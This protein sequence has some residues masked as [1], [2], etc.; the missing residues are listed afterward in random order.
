MRKVL[1]MDNQFIDDLFLTQDDND[2]RKDL[3]EFLI[4]DY[5]GYHLICNFKNEIEYQKALNENP[6][7]EIIIDKFDTIDYKGIIDID[8]NINKDYIDFVIIDNGM[9]FEVFAKN[10]KNILNPYFTTKKKGA[11]L[12][13]AIVNKIINDHNGSIIFTSQDKR[14]KINIKFL[15]NEY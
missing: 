14:A 12:G 1:I 15:K 13:L 2:T 3:F 7:W 11:G 8:L 4:N 5:S 9:G 6:I 10:I